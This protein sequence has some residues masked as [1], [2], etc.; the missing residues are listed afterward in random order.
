[1][2][3]QKLPNILVS[4]LLPN[5]RRNKE[6]TKINTETVKIKLHSYSTQKYELKSSLNISKIKHPGIFYD[7]GI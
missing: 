3:I 7:T 1:M 4:T 6:Y 2:Q 5:F